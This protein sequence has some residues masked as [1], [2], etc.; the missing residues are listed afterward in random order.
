MFNKTLRYYYEFCIIWDINFP[1]PNIIYRHN[2]HGRPYEK[3]FN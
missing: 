1:A 3:N 2:L